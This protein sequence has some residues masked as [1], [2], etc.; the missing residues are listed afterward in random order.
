MNVEFLS[1]DEELKWCDLHGIGSSKSL[2]KCSYCGKRQ[3][4]AALPQKEIEIEIWP[5]THECYSCHSITPVIWVTVK[6][7]DSIVSMDPDSLNDLNLIE[8]IDPN[9]FKDL[10]IKL[11]EL[12][13]SFKK[14]FKQ[15]KNIEQYGNT[16]IN[17]GAYQ[18]DFFVFEEYLEYAYNPELVNIKVIKVTLTDEERLHHASYKKVENM[19][20]PKNSKYELL[21][22]DCYKLYKSKKI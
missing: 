15:I 22:D 7:Y 10:E 19:H 1:D 4:R 21:C 3:Y 13:S 9:S 8:S 20:R 6:G 5:L 2:K 16:C 12:Y 18:G 17:C 11:S 14:V